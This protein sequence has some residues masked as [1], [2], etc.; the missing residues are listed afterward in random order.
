MVR[1]A[2]IVSVDPRQSSLALMKAKRKTKAKSP[3]ASNDPNN[4]DSSQSH[5]DFTICDQPVSS[6]S[7]R[8]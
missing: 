4:S 7:I 5:D 1:T 2:S 6:H 8:K 3:L